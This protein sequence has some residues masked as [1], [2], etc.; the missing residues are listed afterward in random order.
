[1]IWALESI[2]PL[3]VF[4]ALI[5]FL[6]RSRRRAPPHVQVRNE[7]HE[8]PQPAAPSEPPECSTRIP[9]ADD[10]TAPSAIVPASQ[11]VIT[12]E[13]SV[14][15]NADVPALEAPAPEPLPQS[16]HAPNSAAAYTQHTSEHSKLATMAPIC[17][18]LLTVV[19]G[20]PDAFPPLK[21]AL[22]GILEIW[23]QCEVRYHVL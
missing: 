4:V 16:K 7:S 2:A 20:A 22:G 1:M 3:L 9:L 8:D 11:A 23:K 10:S 6:E 12:P 21:S 19:H 13:A 18:D 15:R 17:N 5:G 14:T